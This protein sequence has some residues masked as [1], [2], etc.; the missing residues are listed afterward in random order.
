MLKVFGIF[1]FFVPLSPAH[2]HPHSH[3]LGREQRGRQSSGGGGPGLSVDTWSYREDADSPSPAASQC[4]GVCWKF[5]VR[6]PE[7]SVH[8]FLGPSAPGAT[9]GNSEQPS[10]QLQ[11]SQVLSNAIKLN[12]NS[13]ATLA[14]GVRVTR[15]VARILSLPGKFIRQV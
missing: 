11:N 1:H 15:E 7:K 6:V 10:S 13:F 3:F 2:P 4:P 14:T 9:F 12:V 8:L 5:R